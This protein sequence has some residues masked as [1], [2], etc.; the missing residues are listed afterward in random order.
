M[1]LTELEPEWL[2]YV[3]DDRRQRWGDALNPAE[4][5]GI[6]FLCP[7]CFATNGGPVGT[8][9]VVCW[10][11]GRVPDSASPGPGRWTIEGSSFENLTLAPSIQ[12]LSGCAW[13]GFIRN[14]E[15]TNA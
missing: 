15:A 3:S 4:A 13:H 7:A 9:G 10:F 6:W 12:L 8:H 14:G 2:T 1:R 5:H 11:R